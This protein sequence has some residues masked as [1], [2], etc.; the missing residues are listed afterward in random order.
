MPLLVPYAYVS[1]EFS[2]RKPIDLK[3]IDLKMF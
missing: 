2:L 3:R 1:V